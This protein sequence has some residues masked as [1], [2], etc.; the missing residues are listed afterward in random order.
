MRVTTTTPVSASWARASGTRHQPGQALQLV[1]A[2]PR[3]GDAHPD[4]H[5]GEHA[6]LSSVHS[7]PS[8][9][10]NGPCQPPRKSTADSG[11]ITTMPAYSESRKNANR[12][13]V[14]SV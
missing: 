2:Q 10:A 5:D 3:P 8:W 7:Q 14:Y 9:S 12:S 13:P 1:L 11:D 6:V 4:D